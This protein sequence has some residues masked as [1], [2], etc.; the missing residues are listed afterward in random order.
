M[1]PVSLAVV[2]LACALAE[3]TN[4]SFFIYIHLPPP[5]CN[6]TTAGQNQIVG[7]HQVIPT[8]LRHELARL[9][10]RSLIPN[11]LAIAASPV[12]FLSRAL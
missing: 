8:Y 10:D 2:T 12:M 1:A 5:N 6:R 9:T 4:L 3:R 11:F 7:L